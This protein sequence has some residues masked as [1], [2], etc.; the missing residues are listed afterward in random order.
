MNID[1]K[2]TL[3]LAVEESGFKVT[4]ALKRLEVP[5]STYY[6]WKARL[7]KEGVLG[8]ED[9]KPAPKKQWNAITPD[10]EKVILATAENNPEMSSREISYA[11]TDS[12][13]FSVSESTVYRILKREGLIRASTIESVPAAKEY[14]TK[15][16]HVNEQWQ[17][18]ATYLHVEG[19]GWFY[20]ISILDDFSRKIISWKIMDSMTAEDFAEVI[21]DACDK[22]GV[23]REDMPNLVSDRG[24][25]LISGTLR[26]YLVGK[27]IHHILA[28]PYHPQTNGKIERYHKSLKKVVKLH[29][30][31]CP[32]ELKAEVGKFISQYNKSRYHESLGNV[33]PDDV[34][35]G[36][37]DGIIKVRNQKRRLTFMRRKEYNCGHN[38]VML[39]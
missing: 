36:R 11:I 35:Y 3:L 29:T 38:L 8:L 7:K 10:E 28:R 31:D 34:F 22:A 24:P 19:W 17:T 26:D 32:N 37:R 18:D 33:T 14:H 30:Y 12:E 16:G 25:A 4:E 9:K 5:R 23:V 2:M 6:R 13:Y 21:E 39:H 15:P 27:G 20:L 1:E